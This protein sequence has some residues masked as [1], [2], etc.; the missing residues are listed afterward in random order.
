LLAF[1]VSST[2]G[3]D[4]FAP[5]RYLEGDL[6]SNLAAGLLAIASVGS[7]LC[8]ILV[9][10]P[11]NISRSTSLFWGAWPL[12]RPSLLQAVKA[13]DANYLFNQYLENAD[14]LS[15]IARRKYRFVSLS[16]KTLV[17][18]L[19]AYVWFWRRN[20]R[21]AVRRDQYLRA[22]PAALLVKVSNSSGGWPLRD[23]GRHSLATKAAK[24]STL[25]PVTWR[26]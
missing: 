14:I 25:I 4:V 3:R 17:V 18:T 15:L 16:F 6:A 9:V 7:L 23:V 8:A 13:S 10:L 19:L 20:R 12:H 1:L 22:G 26:G 11:R 24:P 2:D 5:A 21:R